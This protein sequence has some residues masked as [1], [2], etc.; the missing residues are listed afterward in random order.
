MAWAW[1]LRLDPEPLPELGGSWFGAVNSRVI[2][3]AGA[4]RANW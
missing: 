4:G 2:S 3:L 1:W